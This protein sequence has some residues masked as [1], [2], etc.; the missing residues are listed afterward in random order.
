ML[1]VRLT[2]IVQLLRRREQRKQEVISRRLDQKWS[3]C[4]AQNETKCRVL[5]YRY[6][7]ELRKL[8]K[9]RLAAK[10]S[11]FKR[12][13][14][15]DY[16]KPSSQVFAPL[17][18]LGVFPDR[19]SERYV[20]KNIYSSRFEGLLT[21]E[22]SLPRFVFRPRIR[23][24]QPIIHT[25][26]GFL[27]RKYRHQKELAEL[28]DVCLFTCIKLFNYRKEFFHGTWKVFIFTWDILF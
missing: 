19:S 10:E 8:L 9:L 4:C 25:K 14:I 16:A 18:R 27:K 6:I 21:L 7:G 11:K 20:V 2:V 22:A 3:E 15:I 13:I 5:K 26:D 23:L 28:H 1:E 24:Q 17:T 12:D